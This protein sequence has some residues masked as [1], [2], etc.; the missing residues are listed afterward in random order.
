MSL[1]KKLE[2]SNTKL[3]LQRRLIAE[4]IDRQL[5]PFSAED[6]HR[7]GLKQ[8]RVDLATIYRTLSL[9]LAQ[10]FL[11]KS[12]FGDRKA[13]YW[14]KTKETHCQTLFCKECGAMETLPSCLAHDQHQALA[15]KGY[16]HLS[17]RVEFV[18]VCPACTK[19]ESV[20]L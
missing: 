18:G 6:L 20:P 2:L 5:Q 19:K 12:E 1:L 8:K 7:Q 16:T 3:T 17:H 11:Q 9:F 15:R 14:K 10:D 4:K 13:R